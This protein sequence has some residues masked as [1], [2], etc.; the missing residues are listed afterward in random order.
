MQTANIVMSNVV[1]DAIR[2]G[3]NAFSNLA[4]A[5][6]KRL[7]KQNKITG[8]E[9]MNAAFAIA[10]IKNIAKTPAMY[11]ARA[12]TEN[13]WHVRA[14]E[15]AQSKGLLH[16]ADA[17][18]IV[19]DPKGIVCAKAKDAFAGNPN[20]EQDFYDFCDSVQQWEYNRTNPSFYKYPM[21]YGLMIEKYQDMIIEKSARLVKQAEMN[22]V[23][24]IV[25]P[26]IGAKNKLAELIHSKSSHRR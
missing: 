24:P 1:Y 3:F 25:R 12:E 14:A 7:S 10:Y 17:F 8:D 9:R 2:A 23:A 5:N 16:K 6:M 22:C 13:A 11:F 19:S 18:Y 4:H 21:T 15:Y 26:V 20:L